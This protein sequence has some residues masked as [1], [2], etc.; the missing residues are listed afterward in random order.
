VSKSNNVVNTKAKEEANES[1]S[2]RA[3]EA[4][5]QSKTASSHE[6]DSYA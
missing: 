1:P 2:E 4:K 6:I 3:A 5:K